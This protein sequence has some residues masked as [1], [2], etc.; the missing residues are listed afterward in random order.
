MNTS[1]KILLKHP[2][3][4]K[5]KR[6]IMV[7]DISIKEYQKCFKISIYINKNS[8]SFNGAFLT[9]LVLSRLARLMYIGFNAFSDENSFTGLTSQ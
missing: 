8:S 5:S 4:K 7:L 3:F 2:T 6:G 9:D 1:I